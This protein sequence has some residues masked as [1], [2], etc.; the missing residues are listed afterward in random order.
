MIVRA[1]ATR[2]IFTTDEQGQFKVEFCAGTNQQEPQS[3]VDPQRKVQTRNANL[4]HHWNLSKL[5]WPD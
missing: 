3:V 2:T 1:A 5:A 4:H